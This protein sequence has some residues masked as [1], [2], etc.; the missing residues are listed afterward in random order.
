[1][2]GFILKIDT[3]IGGDVFSP[4]DLIVSMEKWKN[5]N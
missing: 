4:V 5:L 2:N 3:H 1:M